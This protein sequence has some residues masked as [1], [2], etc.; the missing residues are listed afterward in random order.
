M[1]FNNVAVAVLPCPAAA[2]AAFVFKTF[3]ALKHFY[4]SRVLL[5]HNVH[6]P[7]SGM[8]H[9]HPKKRRMKENK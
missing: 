8:A 5:A 6:A 4:G 3:A 1:H 2:A 9:T 7:G